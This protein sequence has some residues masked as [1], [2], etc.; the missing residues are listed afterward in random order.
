MML[1]NTLTVRPHSRTSGLSP[2]RSRR[3]SP[4]RLI[5]TSASLAPH[6]AS[7]ATAA[8]ALTLAAFL[9]YEEL[10]TIRMQVRATLL[11]GLPRGGGDAG[12][13]IE[14]SA[15]RVH[16]RWNAVTREWIALAPPPSRDP[17]ARDPPDPP[18]LPPRP[19]APATDHPDRGFLHPDPFQHDDVPIDENGDESSS[20]SSSSS[21]V[22]GA[23]FAS[24]LAAEPLVI[25]PASPMAIVPDAPCASP[26]VNGGVCDRSSGACACPT[27]FTGAAC[28]S[29]DEYP[30]NNPD[31]SFI[32][33]W[34]AGACD[35]TNA[36]CSCGPGS[37]HPRRTVG[38][39]CQPDMSGYEGW[40]GR[41]RG[42]PAG[43]R[44]PTRTRRLRFT[45]CTTWNHRR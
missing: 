28:D 29:P 40:T 15:P 45:G 26:C 21:S 13:V 27:G 10:A 37:K 25:R 38:S 31:G 39:W 32:G 22:F 7:Q 9:F 19:S 12:V 23:G 44:T 33:S 6:V 8:I 2:P 5:L 24:F 4:V 17:D 18:A 16:H 41:P 30:C 43:V 35:A 34:C 42:A 3:H 36:R 11:R 1:R 14:E 20:S